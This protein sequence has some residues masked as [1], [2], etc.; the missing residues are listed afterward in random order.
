VKLSLLALDYDGTIAERDRLAPEVQ[1]ALLEVHREDLAVVLVTGRI[2]SDLERQLPTLDLF[3]AVV[4]ENGAVLYFPSTGRSTRLARPTDPL[5]LAELARRS[6]S[7]RAG[8]SVVELEGGDA[9]VALEA[10][11]T[12]ELP[13]ALVFNRE[14]LMV[15]PQSVSKAS[16]LREAARAL[17]VSLHN[18]VALG[19]AENDHDMLDVCE[20]GVAVAWGSP[21]LRRAADQVLPG[22]GPAAVGPFLR[23]LTAQPML[24]AERPVTRRKLRLGTCPGGRPLSLGIRGRPVLIAGDPQSGKSWLAGLVCEQ[25]ILQRYCV[26]VIDPEGDYACLDHLSGVMVLNADDDDVASLERI[27][28]TFERIKQTFGHSDVSVVVDL[29]A[30]RPERKHACVLALIA[31]LTAFRRRTGFPHRI[32]LDEAHYF[33][34]DA[35]ELPD[36]D[37][38]GYLLISYRASRLRADV[39]AM[40]EAV[41]VTGLSDASEAEALR[42]LAGAPALPEAWAAT[43]RALPIDGAVLLPGAEEAGAEPI[44]FRID[45]RLTP[46]VRHKHKYLERPVATGRAFVFTRGGKSSGERAQ[47]LAELIA[48]LEATRERPFDGHLKRGDFSR[49]VAEVFRD[50]ELAAGLRAIEA[51]WRTHLAAR[52]HE[53]IV[54]AIRERYIEAPRLLI[55]AGTE[56]GGGPEPTG[57]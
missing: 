49:W 47:S 3:A 16:G 9:P 22:D 51:E 14:R 43:L 55:A 50:A 21:A 36:F 1:Q 29:S 54:R 56:V 13:L 30:L 41:L 4:A 42:R 12:L 32:V 17:R 48:V 27:E 33:L 28:R 40:T 5:L 6:V 57:A 25:L 45:E 44:R 34:G 31:R 53:R 35:T 15:L 38:A 19:D 24:P 23:R 26:C 20:L 7:Y 2:L 10:I 37:A 39:L 8:E 52:P 46:H 18:A 11:R